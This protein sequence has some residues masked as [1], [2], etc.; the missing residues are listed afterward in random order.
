L[1]L[2]ISDNPDHV[3]PTI[4]SRC[5]PVRIPRI[6]ESHLRMNQEAMEEN[7]AHF[8]LF[9]NWMRLCFSGNII[10]LI[11]FANETG[12]IGREKQKSLLLYGL[13]I[14]GT[15]SLVIH[16]VSELPGDQNEE[17]TFI[18]RFS[19]YLTDEKLPAFYDLLNIAI[20]HI[21]RNAHTPTLFLDLSL[22]ITALFKG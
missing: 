10:E 2:L 9:R 20:F 19:P 18:S 5:L 6:S 11:A 7:Q 8:T 3:I 16:G 12:K 22:K 1:F 17:T 13:R 21:E 14:A 4:L 15:G